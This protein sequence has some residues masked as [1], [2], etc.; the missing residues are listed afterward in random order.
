MNS[1]LYYEY[2]NSELFPHEFEDWYLY[3]CCEH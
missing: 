3:K 2:M 1:E